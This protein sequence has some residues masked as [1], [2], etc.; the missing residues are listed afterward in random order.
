MSVVRDY[1]VFTGYQADLLH[2]LSALTDLVR[3][4]QLRRQTFATAELF[5]VG[6]VA[7]SESLR[8]SI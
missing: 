1:L 2:Q 6:V 8:L 7:Y 5:Q 4:P 3:S